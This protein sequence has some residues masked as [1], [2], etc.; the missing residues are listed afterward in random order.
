MSTPGHAARYDSV[1]L[2]AFGGPEQMSAVRPFLDNVLRGRP[3][4]PERIEEVVRHYER[5]GGRSPL[6]ELTRRQARALESLLSAQ[7]PAL[8]VYIGMRNW[9]P[10]LDETLDEMARSGLRRAVGVIL[11]AQQNE[12]GWN[13]YQRDVA[14]ARQRVPTAPEVEF[15]APWS[16]HPL[17]I[18]AVS[19]R[20]A[21]ARSQ[22]SAERQTGASI[23]F[24]A[25][26][27]P[28]A[29]AASSPYVEQIEAGARAVCGRLG[30]SK[31]RIAYQS[32]SGNP[33]EAWLE[34]DIGE[35]VR[36]EAGRG[37]R[38]LVV[39]PI[40]FVCDHVEVL[41]DLDVEARHMAESAGIRLV[42]AQTV[43]DHPAFVRMLA[44]VVGRHVA[45]RQPRT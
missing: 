27:I 22:L 18:E 6:N 32:R 40:G 39:V 42:R 35:V 20:L 13:R 28:V 19:E 9:H 34:P 23:V 5:I 24:T 43:N 33:R 10:F 12:A 16:T 21:D 29:M 15:A 11:A 38:D 30:L 36:E 25:H 2:I 26:S 7:G 1:L 8:P 4:P 14:E 41:Y 3:V 17:F 44:E 45:Q 37:G 31:Y